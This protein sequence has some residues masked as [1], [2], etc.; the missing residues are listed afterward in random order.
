MDKMLTAVRR[1]DVPKFDRQEFK[2]T[3]AAGESVEVKMSGKWVDGSEFEA[4]D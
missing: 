1:I 2:D 4:Y 3:A